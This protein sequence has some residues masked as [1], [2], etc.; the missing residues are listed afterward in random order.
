MTNRFLE[1][2]KLIELYPELFENKENG[3]LKIITHPK[4]IISEESKLKK[5]F[6]KNNSPEEWGD[7]GVLVNDPYFFVVRDL[8]EFPNGRVGGYIRFINR[9]SLEGGKAVA[10]LPFYKDKIILIKNFRHATRNWELEIPRGFGEKNITAEDNARKELLEETGLSAKRLVLIGT[11]NIDT[12]A[13]SS[14]PAYL[15]YAEVTELKS[16]ISGSEE[17]ISG[18]LC[19]NITE[20]EDMIKQGNITD[21][22][23]ISTY[24]MAKLKGLI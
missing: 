17:V 15:F 12:A 10:I 20:F 24:S 23:T 22:F 8:V 9:K 1:Y 6:L 14:S 19:L 2:L 11:L 4:I 7:I 5:E 13:R 21:S 3:T 16:S 18:T